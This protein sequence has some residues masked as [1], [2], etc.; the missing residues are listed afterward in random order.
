M[1]AQCSP[2]MSFANGGRV[3]TLDALHLHA[4]ALSQDYS[5][6][7]DLGLN[8]DGGDDQYGDDQ[9]G[10]SSDSDDNF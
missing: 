4:F 1:L 8:D 6:D 2:V 3:L 10:L 7:D 5:D 9:G